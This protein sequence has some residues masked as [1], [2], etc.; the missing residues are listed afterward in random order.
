MKYGVYVVLKGAHTSVCGPDGICYFNTTGN[1]GMATGGSG[2]VLAGLILG[3]LAQKY[4]PVTACVIAV[5][6]HGLAG[7]FAAEKYG[8][9]ALTAGSIIE[10]IGKAFKTLHII[11]QG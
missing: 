4:P 9:E 10:K 6:I 5:Y 1:P 3:L 2:D 8:Y 7:D 11:D